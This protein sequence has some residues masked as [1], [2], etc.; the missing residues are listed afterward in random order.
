M[1]KWLEDLQFRLLPGK[2]I[3]CGAKSNRNIDLCQGCEND[4]PRMEHPCWQCG[5]TIPIGQEICGRCLT[6][7]PLF[8]HCYSAFKYA[9]PVDTLI[10]QFKNHSKLVNGKVL[11]V[12]MAR[13]YVSDHIIVPDFWLPVPLHK[14]RLKSRGF[15]QA[16]EIATTLADMTQRPI[17][18][19]LCRRIAHTPDQKSLNF[20]DRQANIRKAFILDQTLSGETIGIVDD[21]ITTS[22]TVS[23]L[24]RLLL[25]NGAG[26]IQVVSLARTPSETKSTM[27]K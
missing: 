18:S 5:L 15:N 7:P 12:I 14:N 21:V 9:A 3:L 11:S 16:F 22:A 24:T 27:V 4:L 8:S 10:N 13:S 26:D 19:R 23:E 1:N 6:N 17:N 25:Q 20:T 2:C